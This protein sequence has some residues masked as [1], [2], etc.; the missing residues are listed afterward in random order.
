MWWFKPHTSPQGSNSS[1]APHRQQQLLCPNSIILIYCVSV[2]YWYV[3]LN[4]VHTKSEL[5][6]GSIVNLELA[7]NIETLF[8]QLYTHILVKISVC[9][10]NFGGKW[11]LYLVILAIVA[12]IANYRAG[13]LCTTTIFVCVC[14]IHYT[15]TT[16][17]IFCGGLGHD[18]RLTDFYDCVPF[19][20]NLLFNL[21]EEKKHC[22]VNLSIISGF[23]TKYI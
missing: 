9:I 13:R 3:F 19:V 12:T 14:F 21:D 16:K 1:T 22:I 20:F 5:Y 23:R 2:Q 6:Y 15:K 17:L 10:I 7:L 4:F 18:T 11:P 8:G